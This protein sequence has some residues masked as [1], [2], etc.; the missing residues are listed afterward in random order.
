M[1]ALAAVAVA[2]LV[3]GGRVV[4]GQE[5]TAVGTEPQALPLQPGWRWEV[6][7]NVQ[8]QVPGNWEQSLWAGLKTPCDLDQT[9]PKPIVRRPGGAVLAM[10]EPCVNPKAP[11]QHVAPSLEF[12]GDQPGV[13]RYADGWTKETRRIGEQLV[14]VTSADDA[15]RAELFATAG[16][17]TDA[18][19]NGCDPASPSARNEI[20]RPPAHGGLTTVGEVASVSVCRYEEPRGPRPRDDR[21]PYDLALQ[22]SSRLTGPVAAR[23]VRDL[24]AAPPGTGPTVTDQRACGDDPSGEVIVLRVDGSAH[25]QDVVYRYAGCRHN[26]TDDGTTLR[27]ATSATAKAIFVGVHEPN[28]V[29][30]VLHQ[31]LYGPPG[32]VL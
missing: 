12:T 21:A 8:V 15:L 23:L 19:G 25:D 24:I 13:V 14:T 5:E 11:Q 2:A 7:R 32:P 27:Q 26:G 6:Y 31:L 16:V 3:V 20:V 4:L 1:I 10:L 18:D 9:E 17:V 28:G 22:A 29:R 30:N